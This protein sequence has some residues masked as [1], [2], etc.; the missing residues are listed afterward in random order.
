MYQ[1]A[2]QPHSLK[3]LGY[4]NG[5]SIFN[6]HF[7]KERLTHT[8]EH[9]QSFVKWQKMLKT[10]FKTEPCSTTGPRFQQLVLKLDAR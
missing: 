9:L 10:T 5:F 6:H 4:F 8:G 2:N 3:K 1:D 7:K